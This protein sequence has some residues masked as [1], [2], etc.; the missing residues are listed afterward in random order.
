LWPFG[1]FF[2]FWYVW[3]KK[4]LATLVEKKN[5]FAVNLPKQTLKA[6]E[7]KQRLRFIQREGGELFQEKTEKENSF[8]R[9]QQKCDQIGEIL[10]IGR[11]FTLD[12][13]VKITQVDHTYSWATFFYFTGYALNI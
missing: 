3:T 7:N 2:P 11:L 13:F 8:R 5:S 1:T 12:R 4:Y 6:N 10:Y 9:S